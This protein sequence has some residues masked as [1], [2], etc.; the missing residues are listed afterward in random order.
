MLGAVAHTFS[1]S[2]SGEG[3][4]EPRP[5]KKKKKKIQQDPSQSIK[6]QAWQ[7]APVIPAAW[8]E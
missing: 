3:E 4:Q 7:C 8:E 6:S 2:Y 5:K 1:P